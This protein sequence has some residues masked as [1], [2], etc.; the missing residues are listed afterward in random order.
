MKHKNTV[1]LVNPPN[2]DE[3]EIDAGTIPLGLLYLQSFLKQKRFNVQ[4]RNLYHHRT[5]SSVLQDLNTL[6]FDIVGIPVFTQQ[7]KSALNLAS[8]VKK[9][10]SDAVV[11]IG[12]PHATFLDSEI[13]RRYRDIDYVVRSEGELTLYELLKHLEK[14][15][16]SSSKDIKGL[17]LRG[18]KGNSIIRTPPRKAISN[19]DILPDPEHVS[20]TLQDSVECE[21]L[22][23]HFAN[24]RQEK[25]KGLIA[26]ILTSRGCPWHRCIWCCNGAYWGKARYRSPGRVFSEMKRLSEQFGVHFF[27]MYDDAFTG[28]KSNA[29]KLC[30]LISSS[31]MNTRFWCSSRIGDVDSSIL[32]ALKDAG[33]FMIS[34]GMESG[35]QEILQNIDKGITIEQIAQ[36]SRSTKNAGLL[37]RVTMCVGNPGESRKSVSDTVKLLKR[38][39]PDRIG[40]FI[41]KVYPGT[42][43]YYLAIEKGLLSDD[44]W[45]S[46]DSELVPFYTAENSLDQLLG[47]MNEILQELDGR[48]VNC[49]QSPNHNAELSLQWT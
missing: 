38:I 12:G 14:S 20:E 15:S 25:E 28:N 36:V 46:S 13:I 22:Q 42:P 32:A 30:K 27:D 33:C 31:K 37:L 45:F 18:T 16:I 44:Y 29:I 7:R 4:L 34:Y 26:P 10:N 2:I 11:V 5:W 3:A 9:I 41:T 6:E 49:Y 39:K 43:L 47:F 19:L 40:L 48:I 23:F 1:L 35:S 17:T 21:S 8:F 24:E